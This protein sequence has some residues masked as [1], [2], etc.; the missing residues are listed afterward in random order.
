M[1]TVQQFLD[2]AASEIGYT[3]YPPGSN[4][5]KFADEAGHLNDQPWCATFVAAIARR[6]GLELPS[7]N[8]YT[9]TMMSGFERAGMFGQSPSP[10]SIVFFDWL[11]QIRRVQHVGIVKEVYSSFIK[12]IEGNT[13][14]DSKGSQSNGGGVYERI[15]P[16]RDVAGYG[17]PNFQRDQEATEEEEMKMV[18]A[19]EGEIKQYGGQVWLT[20]GFLSRPLSQSEVDH[21][22]AVGVPGPSKFAKHVL[23]QTK[24]TD[25][26]T[27]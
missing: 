4:R 5:N 11:D 1:T 24:R 14:P 7:Y 6:T 23:V 25:G 26:D 20:N 13:S 8:P 15:R 27:W 3:E 18:V 12:T 22:R 21:W 19:Y 2:A 10:G 16:Y 9:P 17:Y